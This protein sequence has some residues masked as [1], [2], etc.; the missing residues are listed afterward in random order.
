MIEYLPSSIGGLLIGLAATLMLVSIGR[1]TGVSG[2]YWGVISKQSD[3]L[4]RLIFV[5]GLPLGTFAFHWI[6][7]IEVPTANT[8]YLNAVLGGFIVGMGVKL[9]SGC[10]SGHGVCG[11]GRLSPRSLV[12]TLVFMLTGIVTVALIKQTVF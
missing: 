12:A 8:F 7:Q 11:I 5:I 1:I 9:G 6:S 3:K 10:T 4:W 2:I